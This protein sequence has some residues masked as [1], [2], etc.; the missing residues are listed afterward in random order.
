MQIAAIDTALR[1]WLAVVTGAPVRG[2]NA[3]R[4]HVALPHEGFI[5][6]SLPHTITQVGEDY[7]KHEV[8]LIDPL[9]AKPVLVARRE[10]T[11][12]VRA[13]S[14]SQ[15]PGKSGVHF[16]ERV[17]ESL[18]KPSTLAYLKENNLAIVRLGPTANF[19][20]PF[21]DRIESICAAELRLSCVV[22]DAENDASVGTIGTVEL[23]SSLEG[24]DGVELPAPPN[25]DEEMIPT[26]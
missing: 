18:K 22:L 13:I 11:V 25:L 21:D 2:K 8:D 9:L 5:E 16:V 26:P 23:S 24:P 10:F 6:V 17:R 1:A 4:Q 15:T 20:A 7:I 3:P 19:D 12:T 14:R